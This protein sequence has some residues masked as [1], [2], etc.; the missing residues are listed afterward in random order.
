MKRWRFPN[1]V[2]LWLAL[3]TGCLSA[4]TISPGWAEVKPSNEKS[5]SA[6]T[7]KIRHLIEHPIASAQQ[8]VQSP[9]PPNTPSAE[10]VQVTA[11]KANPTAKGVEVILQTTKGE[12][13]QVTN[14]SIGNSFIADIPN[15]QLR[16]PSGE[17]FSWCAVYGA[18]ND[19]VA[20]LSTFKTL[21]I[22]LHYP[23]T[24]YHHFS[25]RQQP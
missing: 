25:D 3:I 22:K 20:I 16:L 15:A 6:L 1:S 8:L 10:V 4:V 23:T 7:S 18:G 24:D 9:A 14:R 17:G 12:Q 5:K 11:V 13:L 19:F 2:Y 21:L